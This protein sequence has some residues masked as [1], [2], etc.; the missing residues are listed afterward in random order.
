MRL[1][2]RTLLAWLDDTLSPAEVR[3]IGKQVSESPFAKELVEKIHKVTRQRRLTIPP[4]SGPDSIDANIVAS[5]LDNELDPED[6]A[7][8]EKKCLTSDVHLAEVASI[9]QILSLIGQK[10]KV[11]VEARR[12]MYGLVRGR[13]AVPAA[14]PRASLQTEPEPVSEPVQ[15]WVTPPPPAR[16]WF[17][18]YGP[19]AA[20]VGLIGLLCWSAWKTLAPQPEPVS[21]TEPTVVLSRPA[22][23]P[24]DKTKPT[25]ETKAT[26]AAAAAGGLAADMT[27]GT[28]PATAAA[29]ASPDTS[30]DTTKPKEATTKEPEPTKGEKPASDIPAGAVGMAKKP[31]G[32]LLRYNPGKREWERLTDAS[33]LMEQDRLMSLA[34]FR[35][36][37]EVGTAEVD[38]VGRSEP[39]QDAGA[40]EVWVRSTPPT[41]AAR[42]ILAQGRLVLHGTAPSLPFE[43]QFANK[44]LSVTPPPGGIVGIERI[45]RRAMGEATASPAVLRV[46]A[47]EGPVKLSAVGHDETLDGPGAVTVEPDGT[48]TAKEQKAAPVWVTET[49]PP[50][51]DQKVGEQF[52]KFF[53]TGR[54][55]MS[56]LVEALDDEQ[57]DVARLAISALS[58]VDDISLIVP[59]L[60]KR[61]DAN[62]PI[63]RQTAIAV[64]RG[65]LAQDAASA[66][67]LREQL[68]RDL[69][70]DQAPIAEKLLVGY[71]A[72]EANDPQT[73]KKLVLILADPDDS[74]VGLRELALDN[75]MRLTGR[76]DLEYDP[77]NP[78]PDSKGLR[79]WTQLEKTGELLPPGAKKAEK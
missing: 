3:E 38:L 19:A 36:R 6:V 72:K 77:E 50:P 17:E 24:V 49:E 79:A 68:R 28:A 2:L 74:A 55:I 14:A 22:A 48:F 10:A 39:E 7:E 76:D 51:F 33:G 34:P 70:D 23:A 1:T 75:L 71:S 29:A 21:A 43:I 61:G 18:R 20:V 13:E 60:N 69:G 42:V 41:L 64:L 8:L 12:R 5:Y 44:T 27:K 54:P 62:A 9:H 30:K 47:V 65:F 25:E 11:P 26:E 63:A 16:P 15:P 67:T 66:K 58:A 45:N 73:Y 59:I 35:S 57:K 78:K 46:F 52:V 56:S 4:R 31:T 53:R 37:L 40:S 32:L